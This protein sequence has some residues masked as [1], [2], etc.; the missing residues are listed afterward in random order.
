MYIDPNTGGVLFQ[1]LAVVLGVFSGAVL[2]FSGKIRAGLAR[3]RRAAVK[4]D[5]DDSATG[6]A[7][8]IPDDQRSDM[9][10]NEEPRR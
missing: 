5:S 3:F 6:V 2:L 9:V 1:V 4:D 8:T 10:E 7:S